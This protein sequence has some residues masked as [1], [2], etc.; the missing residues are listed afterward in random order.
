MKIHT[1]IESKILKLWKLVITFLCTVKKTEQK[2]YLSL[3]QER[4]LL[5]KRQNGI[6]LKKVLN[7]IKIMLPK[8]ILVT[9]NTIA[10][11]ISAKRNLK[12]K[13][14][15]KSFAQ[16]IASQRIDGNLVL[17]MLLENARNAKNNLSQ[18]NI[19]RKTIVQLSV[20]GQDI[21]DVY[22]LTV[23]ECHEY[24]AN[25]ILVHNCDATRYAVTDALN[26]SDFNIY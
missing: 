8:T 20:E 2:R 5:Q 3:T 19:K 10:S 16:I 9:L 24:F 21:D 26:N 18:T 4:L 25:G 15:I 7:G 6:S 14:S 11:V 23:D 13:L 1:I 22:D 12:G 17:T